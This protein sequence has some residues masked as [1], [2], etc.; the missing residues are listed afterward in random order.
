MKSSV[1]PTQKMGHSR[2]RQICIKCILHTRK[3]WLTAIMNQ[4]HLSSINQHRSCNLNMKYGVFP[5][6]KIGDLSG[7]GEIET[8]LDL[9]SANHRLV[10]MLSRHISK[11]RE[12]MRLLIHLGGSLIS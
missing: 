3:E 5:T 2:L 9:L 11:T 4:E 7:H 10:P 8:Y 6:L 1:Y 12:L